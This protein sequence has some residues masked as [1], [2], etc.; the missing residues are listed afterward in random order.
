MTLSEELKW[1]G[2]VNQTTYKDIKSLDKG[3]I[4]FYL[5]VDPSSDSMTIGN[6]AAILLARRFVNFGHRAYMLVGGA[7]GLI[8]DPDGKADERNLK[9]LEEVNRNKRA[10]WNNAE[11]YLLVRTLFSLIIILGLKILNTLIFCVK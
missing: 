7:T 3:R 10:L 5:G 9:T 6:L 1:R 11:I 4:S 8:G 2:L